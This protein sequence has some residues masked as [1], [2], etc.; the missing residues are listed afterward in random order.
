MARRTFEVIDIVEILVHWHAGRSKNEIAASVGV[1]RK[2]IRK[3]VAPAEVAGLVPGGPAPAE[4]DGTGRVR[5]WFPE[6]ADTRLRQVTSPAI[7]AHH[8]FIAAQLAAGCRSRSTDTCRPSA[9]HAQV[10]SHQRVRDRSRRSI[11]YPTPTRPPRSPFPPS[12]S[13]DSEVGS[14]GVAPLPS[15]GLRRLG[16]RPVGE[17]DAD[18]V[19]AARGSRLDRPQRAIVPLTSQT[20]CSTVCQLVDDRVAHH[21]RSAAW[22]LRG[23]APGQPQGPRD[24]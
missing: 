11:R 22:P 1:D 13:N 2:T 12:M 20:R 24:F 16:L 18:G 5:G 3:Y 6:L 4:A 23:E 14:V 8:G 7:G 9:R 19:P 21:A 10:R 15:S 17:D